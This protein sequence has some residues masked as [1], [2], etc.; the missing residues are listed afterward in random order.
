MNK[1]ISLYDLTA[2]PLST[3]AP[4]VSPL[5]EPKSF[6]LFRPR[7]QKKEKKDGSLPL[8]SISFFV[9]HGLSREGNNKAHFQFYMKKV[10]F[11]IY[12]TMPRMLGFDCK[13]EIL[14]ALK[15]SL[16]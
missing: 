11:L 2:L 13:N 7:F 14:T 8:K 3:Q 9:G 5:R 4:C 1:R 10:S 15:S 12:R 6:L 16:F